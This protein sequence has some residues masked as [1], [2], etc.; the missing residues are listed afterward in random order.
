[1]V[2]QNALLN[3]YEHGHLLNLA[4][5]Q[6]QLP[7][8]HKVARQAR[9]LTLLA[10][11]HHHI[12]FAGIQRSLLPGFVSV[13][14]HGVARGIYKLRYQ[15][16]GTARGREDGIQM[17]LIALTQVQLTTQSGKLDARR[18]FDRAVAWKQQAVTARLATFLRLRVREVAQCHFEQRLFFIDHGSQVRAHR[19]TV[20][21]S[22][23]AALQEPEQVRVTAKPVTLVEGLSQG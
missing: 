7:G 23:P 2:E 1:M 10:H 16:L 8:L 22:F 6:F 20:D 19:L 3:H 15:A 17:T 13:H 21:H 4:T 18:G 5:Q 12:E 9:Q 11:S 14:K